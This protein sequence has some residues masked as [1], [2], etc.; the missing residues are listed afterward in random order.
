MHYEDNHGDSVREYCCPARSENDRKLVG[1]FRA[2]ACSCVSHA[3]HLLLQ[4]RELIA[5]LC[6]LL[7]LQIASRIEHRFLQ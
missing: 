5:H 3:K 1:I 4:F 2:L 6:R 7:K